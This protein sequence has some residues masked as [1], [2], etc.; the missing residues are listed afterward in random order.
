MPSPKRP[1][2]TDLGSTKP[3]IQCVERHN[4]AIGHSL[5]PEPRLR[6]SGGI[7]ARPQTPNVVQ[8]ATLV[9]RLIH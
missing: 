2:Q 3:T 9:S 4:C 5:Q 6:K 7:P 8:K 1:G